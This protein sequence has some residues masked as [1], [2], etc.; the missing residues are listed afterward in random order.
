M[1]Q[2]LL[3]VFVLTLGLMTLGFAG[4]AI[5]MLVLKKGEFR[6][7]CSTHNPLL[8]GRGVDCAGCPHRYEDHCPATQHHR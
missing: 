7:T 2:T 6:G 3:V 4:L 5:R 1:M 8:K